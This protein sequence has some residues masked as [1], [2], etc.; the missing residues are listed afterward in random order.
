[1][2]SLIYKIILHIIMN[3]SEYGWVWLLDGEYVCAR[4]VSDSTVYAVPLRI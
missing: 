1:M 3:Y 4:E 2:L